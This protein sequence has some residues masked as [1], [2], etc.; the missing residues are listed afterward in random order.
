MCINIIYIYISIYIYCFFQ[1][2]TSCTD[3]LTYCSHTFFILLNEM[4]AF[5]AHDSTV[6]S[7]E[8]KQRLPLEPEKGSC[9]SETRQY[10]HHSR[11]C[12]P[13]Y[14]WGSNLKS[15]ESVGKCWNHGDTQVY[16]V[17]PPPKRF[18]TQKK[19]IDNH[20]PWK[21]KHVSFFSC[22]QNEAQNGP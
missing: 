8:K 20:G 4:K 16:Q 15:L 2:A 7:R 17:F 22:T 19:K 1:C 10:Q 11:Q 6:G 18:K 21:K 14:N 9:T 12:N 5:C 3:M 13:L